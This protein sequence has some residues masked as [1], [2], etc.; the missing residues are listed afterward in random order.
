MDNQKHTLAFIKLL[1]KKYKRETGVSHLQALE[2]ISRQQGYSNW[3][4]CQRELSQKTVPVIKPKEVLVIPQISFTDWLTKHKNRDSPLGDLAQD[5]MRDSTWPSYN[6]LE[7]YDNYLY[8]KGAYFRA[9]DALKRAWRSYNAYLK[10]KACPVIDK[11]KSKKSTIQQ[12]ELRKIVY[13][14]NVTPLHSSKRTT[15]QFGIGDKAWISWDGSKAIPVTVTKADERNYSVRPERPLKIAG[16][17]QYSLFLDEVR[18]TPELACI[19]R[20]TS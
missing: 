3:A 1:A 20:V 8:F 14:K 17:S 9:H 15:E 7:E 16:R 18:S 11:P 5:M 13:L 6:T 4:H 12:H 10:R 2:A 19:N